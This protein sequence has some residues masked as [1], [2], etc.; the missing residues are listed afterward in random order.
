[1]SGPLHVAFL[2]CGFITRRPQPA[3][4]GP[5]GR[6]R[7]AAT[8]AAISA[9]AEDLSPALR[10]RRPRYGDYAGRDR[11]PGRRRGGRRGAAALSPRPH[12]ARARRRQ[13]RAGREAGVPDDGRL[14][15]GAWRRATA[16]A[17]SS[18]SA[19]TITTSRWPSACV[20]CSPRG[21]IGDMV[22]AHFTTHR[23]APQ[24]RG[25]LAQR[26]SDGRR[27]R[28]LRGGHPLA[29]PG[30]QPRPDDRLGAAATGR[31]CRA[32]ART[33]APRA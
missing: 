1:M 2:G 11:R 17:A 19:R 7:A 16:P 26:R 23:A 32:R 14:S 30:R 10:R 24:D 22:F 9:R 15:D 18:W 12:A 5:R 31:R 8:P 3:A 6:G 27:R 33:A 20:G 29:A 13:A 25:R 21:A 4:P 28:V